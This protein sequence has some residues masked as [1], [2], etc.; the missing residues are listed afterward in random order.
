MWMTGIIEPSIF[1]D[2][3]GIDDQSISVPS[4]GRVSEP[5]GLA[6]IRQWP[7]VDK[8]LPVRMVRLKEHHNESRRL[9]HFSRSVVTV[10]ICHT[11]RKT[12]PARSVLG[13]V[14]QALFV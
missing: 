8:Y 9:N 11:V 14:R 13:V 6:L 3:D 1:L 4:T 2:T 7:A 10:E 5:G 12:T